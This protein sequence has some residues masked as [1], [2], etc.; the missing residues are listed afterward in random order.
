MCIHH[1]HTSPPLS[2]HAYALWLCE[3]RVRNAGQWNTSERT[4]AEIKLFQRE[5]PFSCFGVFACLAWIVVLRHLDHGNELFPLQ[6]RKGAN[7]HKYIAQASNASL[8]HRSLHQ[9]QQRA[10]KR[11]RIHMLQKHASC[12]ISSL[13]R[14]I[15][16]CLW[17]SISSCLWRSIS[18]SL[19]HCTI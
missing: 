15:S 19:C 4:I 13:W 5:E 8:F 3:M 9:T 6:T 1:T 12:S 7:Q 10:A 16:S 14:S 2:S 18:S 17:R 11:A